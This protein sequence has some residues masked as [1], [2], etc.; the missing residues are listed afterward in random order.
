MARAKTNK[1]PETEEQTEKRKV[2]TWNDERDAALCQVLAENVNGEGKISIS[3]AEVV[4]ELM[5][6]ESFEGVEDR[7]NGTNVG[8]RI[9]KLR[10]DVGVPIP[11]FARAGRTGY[12]PNKDELA[13]LFA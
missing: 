8:I 7:L 12:K 3:A 2:L 1:A 9:R 10:K 13:A 5:S 11:P 4:E 6:Y